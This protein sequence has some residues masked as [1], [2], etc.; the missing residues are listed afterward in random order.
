M[1]RKSKPERCRDWP[2]C[3]C[4]DRWQRWSNFD[5]SGHQFTQEQ[6]EDI[7]SDLLFMLAC[8]ALHCPDP[9]LRQHATL[10]LMRPIFVDEAWQWLS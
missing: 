2:Y 5:P 7:K 3:G 10:Q 6:A 8:V 4:G 9:Q 1:S